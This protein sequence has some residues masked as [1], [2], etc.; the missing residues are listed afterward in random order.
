MA[1][2]R[3][4]ASAVVGTSFL[5]VASMWT[6]VVWMGISAVGLLSSL[7]RKT[8]CTGVGFRL[9]NVFTLACLEVLYL[10]PTRENLMKGPDAAVILRKFLVAERQGSWQ[11]VKVVFEVI[12][13]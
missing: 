8:A 4:D 13:R 1:G 10:F 3:G 2:D 7:S 11:R 12:N 5:V 9:K 6:L